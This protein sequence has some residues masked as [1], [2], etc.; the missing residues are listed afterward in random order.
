M[1]EPLPTLVIAISRSILVRRVAS[2]G[3]C[4][5]ELREM[6]D[7]RLARG[8]GGDTLN[9][10]VYLARLGVGVD[11]VTALGDDP[12]SD[13]MVAAWQA[14]GVGTD[15][16]A[17]FPGRLPGLYTIQTSPQG[18]RRFFYWRDRAPARELFDRPEAA[19]IVEAIPKYDLIYFSGIT[20]SLYGEQGRKRLFEVLDRTRGQGGQVV[21]DTNFR[22]AGWPDR[23]IARAAYREAL[24]RSHIV[25]AST[26]DLDL[27]F[28]PSGFAEV[29]ARAA[30]TE[31]I[32]KLPEPACRILSGDSD[33]L[34]PGEPAD[35]V[36]DTTAAGDSFAAAYL[37]A[38]MAG[39]SPAAAARAGHHLA[40]TVVRHPGAIIPAAAMPARAAAERRSEGENA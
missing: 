31:I 1:M 32:L 21:F 12:W 18:E 17:R 34:I 24:D 11:Y 35:T 30:R 37:A 3:E 28:G 22:P 8:Y 9:T 20:L 29:T 36:V 14:E 4:M 5:I 7:G 26:E 23:T 33:I 15:R 38:R 25:F 13:E 2:I 10:A 40:A 19:A 27:L 16:V 39:A 6:L